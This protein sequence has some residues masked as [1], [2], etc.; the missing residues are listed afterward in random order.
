MLFRSA[1]LALRIGGVPAGRAKEAT[2]KGRMQLPDTAAWDQ[3]SRGTMIHSIAQSLVSRPVILTELLTTAGSRIGLLGHDR[4]WCL[5]HEFMDPPRESMIHE[6]RHGEAYEMLRELYLLAHL[7]T[8]SVCPYG[9]NDYASGL[10]VTPPSGTKPTL[11]EEGRQLSQEMQWL[12]SK[13]MYLLHRYRI[14]TI[15]PALYSPRKSFPAVT[16]RLPVDP[17]D[18]RQKQG[19]TRPIL[20]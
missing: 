13:I 8:F 12:D 4:K 1:S 3:A 2:A 16:T 20:A 10:P 9:F 19:T 17:L 6:N 7:G 15:Q 18:L 5:W 11:K 14:N